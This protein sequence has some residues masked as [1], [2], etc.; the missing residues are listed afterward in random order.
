M[1]SSTPQSRGF[2]EEHF[3]QKL[4]KIAYVSYS[5]EMKTKCI[6]TDIVVAVRADY[7]WLFTMW[8]DI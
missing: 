6:R 3:A 2:W 7:I 4:N 8:I 1:L 5:G